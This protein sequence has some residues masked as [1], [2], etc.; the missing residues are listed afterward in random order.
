MGLLGAGG[1]RGQDNHGQDWARDRWVV[2]RPK[3]NRYT[4]QQDAARR[5]PQTP[6]SDLLLHLPTAFPQVTQHGVAYK[7]LKLR[8]EPGLRGLSRFMFPDKEA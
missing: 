8:T 2:G 5:G 3:T 4:P 1:A 6:A 7:L